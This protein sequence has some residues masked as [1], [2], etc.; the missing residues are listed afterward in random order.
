M[1]PRNR[2][3]ILVGMMALSVLAAAAILAILFPSRVWDPFLWRYFWAPI[4]ADAGGDAGDITASYNIYDTLAY[5]IILALSAYYIHRLFEYLDIRVGIWFFI[6]LSP[7]IVIGPSTRVLE[8][9]EL[10]NEPLQYLFISPLIYIFLGISTLITLIISH[11]IEVRSG[12]DDRRYR[13]SSGLFLFLPGLLTSLAIWSSPDWL[14]TS[15]RTWPILLTSLV[16]GLLHPLVFKKRGYE[17]ILFL[18]WVQPLIFTIYAYAHWFG[19]GDWYE[20]FMDIKGGAVPETHYLA[21]IGIVALTLISTGLVYG[22]FRLLST[23]FEGVKPSMHGINVM[24]VGGHLLDASATSIGVDFIG[25]QE[26]HVLPSFLMEN[27]GT[28]FVMFPL[29]LVFIIPALYFIDRVSR[30]SGGDSKHMIALVRLAVLILG[31]APGTRDLIRLAL[32]V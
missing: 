25:Y 14:N 9:M 2:I 6:A 23:R 26:K 5:G 32:G 11:L 27:L 30:E 15:I 3:E 8:D 21:G 22:I 20:T 31:F 1:K 16:V 19:K 18:F 29:K 24:I 10:F 12:P 7:V 13:I 4:V 17:R 28:A